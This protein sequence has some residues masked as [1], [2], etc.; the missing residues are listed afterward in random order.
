M[1]ELA[2]LESPREQASTETIAWVFDWTE[3][4]INSQTVSSATAT[5]VEL[6]TGADVSATAISGAIGVAS[7]N[8]TVTVTN[9]VARKRYR[10]SV[11]AVLSGGSHQV[12]DLVLEAPH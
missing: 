9:L 10:V 12:A 4:L 11:L 6:G 2:V 7:P 1:S 3:R 8:V 5:I